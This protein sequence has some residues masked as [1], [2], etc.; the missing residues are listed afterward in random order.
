MTCQPPPGTDCLRRQ[1][2]DEIDQVHL[3]EANE[4]N[5]TGL[6]AAPAPAPAAVANATAPVEDAA[7]EGAAT[8]TASGAD[9]EAEPE[10]EPDL[11]S[12]LI[13]TKAAA[14][15]GVAFDKLNK[16]RE[17]RGKARGLL[18]QKGKSI[19]EVL[20]KGALD[21]MLAKVKDAKAKLSAKFGSI[22]EV[23]GELEAKVEEKRESDRE[24]K[25]EEAD[26]VDAGAARDKAEAMKAKLKEQ[27]DEKET[28]YYKK[29]FEEEVKLVQSEKKKTA[30][31]QEEAEEQ[32]TTEKQFVRAKKSKK[33]REIEIKLNEKAQ[34]RKDIPKETDAEYNHRQIA[35]EAYNKQVIGYVM[36][37]QRKLE[38]KTQYSK[39]AKQKATQMLGRFTDQY[40]DTHESLA[41]KNAVTDMDLDPVS[42]LDQFKPAQNGEGI[43]VPKRL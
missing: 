38:G 32:A 14:K 12:N 4:T 20:K 35:Q 1:V 11:A 6:T 10:E 22:A 16:A 2:T 34:V 27:G 37:M 28:K 7:S 17:L 18:E 36:N 8:V 41:S 19:P 40:K 15:V 25:S 43:M 24:Q 3:L 5:A 26:K 29:K 39:N 9:V 31:V 23:D 21:D 13:A 30:E 42:V 33:I